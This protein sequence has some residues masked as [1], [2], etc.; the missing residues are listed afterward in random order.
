[1][2]LNGYAHPLLITSHDG[3]PTKAEG[4]DLHP[5]EHGFHQYLRASLLDHDV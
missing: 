2:P 3:R 5:R 1:M 4:N